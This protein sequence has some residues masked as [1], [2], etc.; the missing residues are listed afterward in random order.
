MSN[1]S[2]NLRKFNLRNIR[3]IQRNCK[4]NSTAKF[5]VFQYAGM[6]WPGSHWH[7][8]IS[9][10]YANIYG[11]CVALHSAAVNEN[12]S[13]SFSGDAHFCCA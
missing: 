4:K 2:P 11:V 9:W 10:E 6:L 3:V 7:A 1:D 13:A 12:N 8:L 5:L